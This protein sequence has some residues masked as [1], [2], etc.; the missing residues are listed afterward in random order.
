MA[1]PARKKVAT[2]KKDWV[3]RGSE[4]DDDAGAADPS[5]ASYTGAFRSLVAGESTALIL[6]D[7]QNYIR[8]SVGTDPANLFLNRAAR[9]EGRRAQTYRVRGWL[10]WEATTWTLG[11][12]V[13]FGWRIGAFEQDNGDGGVLVPAGYNMLAPVVFTDNQPDVYANMQRSNAWEHFIAY[14]FATGNETSRR[15]MNLNVAARR[16]LAA[17]E[18]LALYW[19]SALSGVNIRY[20]SFLSTLVSDE[21]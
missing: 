1:R 18:C 10:G 8:E 9:A 6:Y 15:S 4:W 3:F 20:S 7:S 2:V 5:L 13:Y 21:D 14:H 19:E 17:N 16:S 11:N 12:N